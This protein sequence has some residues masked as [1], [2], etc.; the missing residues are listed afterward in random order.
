MSLIRRYVI[1]I[2]GKGSI[3]LYRMLLTQAETIDVSD[4]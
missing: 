3:R 2:S 1:M 4:Q